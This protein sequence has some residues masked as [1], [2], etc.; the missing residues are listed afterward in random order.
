MQVNESV[1]WRPCGVLPAK[2][3]SAGS[4]HFKVN[5]QGSKTSLSFRGPPSG[6]Q[7]AACLHGNVFKR[8]GGSSAAVGRTST[9]WQG[10]TSK[11]AREGGGT[12]GEAGG[13]EAWMPGTMQSTTSQPLTWNL[14]S[15]V[16]IRSSSATTGGTAL[17]CRIEP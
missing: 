10:A 11:A 14:P 6:S 9:A 12:S 7:S 17:P 3:R 4:H 16:G 5:V 13:T 8:S 15:G 1:C 2:L